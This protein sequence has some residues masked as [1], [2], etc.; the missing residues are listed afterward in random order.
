MPP[1]IKGLY[2]IADADAADQDPVRLASQLFSGGCRLVQLRAKGWSSAEILAAAK[3]IVRLGKAYGA[4]IIINDFA[5]I[6]LE[7]EADGV[8]LGQK[9]HST[10]AV[11]AQVGRNM[12][13][14]R[15]TNT[16]SEV[17]KAAMEADYVAFGPVF[18]TPH[19]GISKPTTG[20]SQL[21]EAKLLTNTKPLV[22]IGGINEQNIRQ[23][24]TAG[25]DAWAVIGAVALAQNVQEATRRLV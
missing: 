8:H 17:A 3:E 18:E 10:A 16:L 11:R 23:V 14:G 20:L 4:I 1:T 15:S 7:A 2:G 22:A 5:Q 6:A 13:I 25:A 12:I 9:D 24:Q 21:T 19:I